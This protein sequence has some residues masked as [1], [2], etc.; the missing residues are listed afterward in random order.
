MHNKIDLITADCKSCIDHI[1]VSHNVVIDNSII[2]EEWNE[3]RKL[4]DH[5]GIAVDLPFI[6]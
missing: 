6:R 4:S 5:K 3:D 2:I 1:A